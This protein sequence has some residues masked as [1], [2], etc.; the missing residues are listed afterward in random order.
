[1]KRFL[2]LVLVLMFMLSCISVLG[3]AEED[4]VP[5]ESNPEEMVESNPEVTEEVVNAT[6]TIEDYVPPAE[7]E[8]EVITH[9]VTITWMLDTTGDGNMDNLIANST[10]IG[11]TS[12]DA[13]AGDVI[14]ISSYKDNPA[15]ASYWQPGFINYNGIPC[16]FDTFNRLFVNL[17][18]SLDG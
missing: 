13:S 16:I 15:G 4:P 5:V 18:S 9:R 2:C 1:M 7:P 3:F 17:I 14:D 6:G 11:S 8:V 10:L 12:F